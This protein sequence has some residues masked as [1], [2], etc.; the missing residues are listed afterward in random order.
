LDKVTAIQNVTIS[1]SATYEKNFKESVTFYVKFYPRIKHYIAL[2]TNSAADVEDLAQDVFVEFYGSGGYQNPEAYLFGIARR[3]VRQYHLLRKKQAKT[4]GSIEEL[5]VK[6]V[7]RQDGERGPVASQ[8]VSKTILNAL[9]RLSPKAQEALKLRF[10]E[11]LDPKEAARKAGCSV[12]TFCQRC[13]A[14][15]RAL[16]KSQISGSGL[17]SGQSNP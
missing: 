4:V 8:E 7:V 16:Q 15:I 17:E 13:Y 11:G 6:L 3:C 1:G 10:I 2:R 12:N 14:G 5:N 9:A